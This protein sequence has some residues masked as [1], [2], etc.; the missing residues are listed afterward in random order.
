MVQ[1]Y[2]DVPAGSARVDFIEQLERQTLRQLTQSIQEL[3]WYFKEMFDTTPVPYG[4]SRTAHLARLTEHLVR[5]AVD[6]A[7]IQPLDDY[8][9]GDF[10]SR[11]VRWC[12]T[13]LGTVA[14]DLR[15]DAK[16]ESERSRVRPSASQF[17]LKA[18]IEVTSPQTGLTRTVV[19]DRIVVPHIALPTQLGITGAP[20]ADGSESVAAIT[21][22]VFVALFYKPSL[23]SIILVASPHAELQ[24]RYNPDSA[25][26]YIWAAG[27]A[28]D[29]PR[30]TRI[31]LKKLRAN[32]F[33]SWRVQELVYP[34]PTG[35]TFTA[36]VWVDGPPLTSQPFAFMPA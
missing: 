16:A 8:Y 30:V 24:G 26:N 9:E 20:P 15:V 6:R 11:R 17:S 14:Q 7:A 36:P 4:V 13:Y 31:N 35:I 18:E 22:V 25:A 12:P 5:R 10:D 27:P 33:S 29:D 2:L 34:D 23:R 21:T 3:S 1:S 32:P 19:Q 28:P